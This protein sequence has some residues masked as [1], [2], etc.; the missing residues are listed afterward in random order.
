MKLNGKD[1]KTVVRPALSYGTATRGQEIRLEVNEMRA[2]RWMCGVTRRDNIRNEPIRL[3]GYQE[4]TKGPRK[5]Q[6]ND[7]SGT[8]TYVMMVREKHIIRC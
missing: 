3:E 2:L 7:K 8:A 6:K 5:L 4:W 1:Y